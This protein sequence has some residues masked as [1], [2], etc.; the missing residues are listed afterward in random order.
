MAQ[1]ACNQRQEA[2]HNKQAS[3][4]RR[5]RPLDIRAAAEQGSITNFDHPVRAFL[6]K[7]CFIFIKNF[8]KPAWSRRTFA[9]LVNHS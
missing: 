2:T 8:C 9:F 4:N 6:V 5:T 7:P 1:Q 3:I